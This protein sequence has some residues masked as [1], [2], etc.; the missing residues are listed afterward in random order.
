MKRDK[1]Q[2]LIDGFFTQFPGVG[3]WQKATFE[4]IVD[5]MYPYDI[6]EGEQRYASLWTLPMTGRRF[7]FTE[8]ASPG[9]LRKKT[10]R[11]WSF[12][13]TQT[14]NYPIQ[15]CAGGDLVMYALYWL[16]LNKNNYKFLLTV[17]DSILIETSEPL[18]SVELAVE[19]MCAAT[20]GH[21]N[22]PVNL[23]CD[24]SVGKHWK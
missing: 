7:T 14:S 12:S 3:T 13:P 19:Q 23:H 18:M 22:L 2:K 9:W 4:D 15:G 5:G 24:V 20:T 21:F 8:T 1:V 16:W 6:K 10:H 11:K 17:H